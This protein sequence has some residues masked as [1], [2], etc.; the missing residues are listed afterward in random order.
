MNFKM[1]NNLKQIKNFKVR[2]TT[3]ELYYLDSR[4]SKSHI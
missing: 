1:I 4:G 3:R 2:N